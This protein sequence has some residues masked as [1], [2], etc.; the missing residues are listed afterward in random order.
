MEH[1]EGVHRVPG[2]RGANAYLLTFG[3]LT[4]VDCGLPGSGRA[5][6]DFLAALGHPPDAL[7]RILLTHRHPDHCGA[8]T[9][10]RQRTGAEVCAHAAETEVVGEL[11]VVRGTL[12]L[13]GA[14]V[15]RLLE[16]GEEL[17]GGIRAVHCGG[18]T[19]GSLSYYVPARGLLFLGD[20][21]INNVDRLSR[22]IA[23]SNED[24]DAY[25]RGLERLAALGAEAG[26]FGHGPPLTQGLSSALTALCQRPRSPLWRALLRYAF[27]RLRHPFGRD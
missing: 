17:P 6:I 5:I 12:N 9:Y 14:I 19:A 13:G 24:S 4:L 7:Q 2:V 27:L 21:A 15:D 25:E 1:V 22:P 23:F 10:L 11:R 18:H 20:M 26:F 8:A 3:P 16:D